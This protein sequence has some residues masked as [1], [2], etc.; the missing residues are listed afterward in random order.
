MSLLENSLE[1]VRKNN[2]INSS[3]LISKLIKVIKVEGF[4][5]KK[6]YLTRWHPTENL[7]SETLNRTKR[8]VFKICDA[9]IKNK[10]LLAGGSV[11]SAF[12][13]FRINDLDIYVNRKNAM[14]IYED[15]LDI[16]YYKV[17]NLCLAPAYDQSFFRKNHILSRIRLENDNFMP[18]DLM[19]I[20]DNISLISVVTNFDL[21]FC[22]I[23]FDGQNVYAVDP[24]GIQNKEGILKPDYLESL[25]KYFNEFI[26]KR[27]KKYISRGF[28]ISYSSSNCSFLYK[29]SEIKTINN[30][31]GTIRVSS[32]DGNNYIYPEEWVV[33]LVLN[34]FYKL[35]CQNNFNI[36]YHFSL[37]K[38]TWQNLFSMLKRYYHI[39]PLSYGLFSYKGSTLESIPM[40]YEYR[41]VN[42]KDPRYPEDASPEF[43]QKRVD[44]KVKLLIKYLI[45]TT[46]GEIFEF[47]SSNKWSEYINIVLNSDITSEDEK[48]INGE[49]FYVN[50]QDLRDIALSSSQ[51]K[52][53]TDILYMENILDPTYFRHFLRPDTEVEPILVEEDKSLSYKEYKN[54]LDKYFITINQRSSI[55]YYKNNYLIPEDF[56]IL[57][58]ESYSDTSMDDWLKENPT[59]LIFLYNSVQTDAINGIKGVGLTKN[60]LYQLYAKLIVGCKKVEKDTTNITQD[61]VYIHKIY[62]VLAVGDSFNNGILLSKLNCV[63]DELEK[64]GGNRIFYL[65]EESLLKSISSLSNVVFYDSRWNIYGSTIDNVSSAHCHEGQ[66]TYVYDCIYI[67]DKSKLVNRKKFDEMISSKSRLYYYIRSND[68]E[69]GI[70]L[71]NQIDIDT[72]NIQDNVTGNTPLM[73]AIIEDVHNDIVIAII[74]KGVNVNL[75]NNDGDTALMIACANGNVQIVNTLIKAGANVDLPNKYEET[76]IIHACKNEN[77]NLEIVKALIEKVA[78]VDVQ[79]NDGYTSLMYA[80]MDGNV[81]LVTAFIKAHA[82]VNLQ[83]NDGK[84]ALDIARDNNYTQIVDILTNADNTIVPDSNIEVQDEERNTAL[85]RAC[86]DDDI[87]EVNRLIEVGVDLDLQDDFG[88][89][90]LIVACNKD[91]VDLEIVNAL[92]EKGA[93]VDLQNTDGYTAL[94]LASIYNHMEIVV[95]LIK[96]NANV[97]LQNI[98]GDTALMIASMRNNTQIAVDL[99][100]AHANVDLQNKVGKTALMIASIYNNVQI[101][102]ALIAKGAKPN[103]RDYDGRNALDFAMREENGDN[104]YTDVIISIQDYVNR[105]YSNT[106]DSDDED[107][108]IQLYSYISNNNIENAINLINN[109]DIDTLNTQNDSGETALMFVIYYNH[110]DDIAIA[111]INKGVNLDLQDENGYTAL[112]MALIRHNMVLVNILLESG[113]DRTIQDNYGNSPL[114]MLEPSDSGERSYYDG[115][116]VNEKMSPRRY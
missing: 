94:M 20:P 30:P 91:H 52:L 98:S 68:F 51:T 6:S 106:N 33:K 59:N 69:N 50:F 21:S 96:K 70:D 18:I 56:E 109:M 74:N 79:D 14:T 47:E 42:P 82:D 92:I 103:L 29:H 48:I 93:N 111:L 64:E 53:L 15:L 99:I 71:I 10:A 34:K 83:N 9:L 36:Y 44:I 55:S 1:N 113:A 23:W 88:D 57:D 31:N 112:S 65:E 110:S 24:E 73:F 72:L 81:E 104:T 97:N 105:L 75:Q 76:A 87:N 90:A 78:N 67:I 43:K 116:F 80:S 54:I 107:Q 45:L 7:D 27:I 101:V 8:I 61:I 114:D 63:K 60:A 5:P 39:T 3:K 115:M 102:N 100:Q 37:E 85:I 40:P 19:I 66:Q 2:N 38:F 62:N 41:W 28:K 17:Q 95:A 22:E 46:L 86:L 4:N 58:L 89:T 35:N 77:V 84:T 49:N 25:F 13:D 32:D 12:S 108:L 26:R 11:L 16:G